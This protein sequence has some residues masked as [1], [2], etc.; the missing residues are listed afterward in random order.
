MRQCNRLEFHGLERVLP[1]ARSAKHTHWDGLRDL[2][3][4]P[5]LEI[6]PTNNYMINNK[7]WNL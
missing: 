1:L 5:P 2:D 4:H 7:V 6:K 3:W